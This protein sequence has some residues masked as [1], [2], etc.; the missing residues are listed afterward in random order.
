MYILLWTLLQ[1]SA[2]DTVNPNVSEQFTVS[3]PTIGC[4]F[5]III[6]ESIALQSRTSQYIY[7]DFLDIRERTSSTKN[8]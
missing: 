1:Q 2:E 7:I 8:M 4:L 6:L 5:D 3:I